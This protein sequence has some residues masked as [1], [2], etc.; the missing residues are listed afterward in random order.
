MAFRVIRPTVFPHAPESMIAEE[1]RILDEVGAELVPV[2]IAPADLVNHVAGAD[3]LIATSAPV[4]A[5]VIEAMP[6]CRGI[7]AASIGFDH[8]DLAAATARGIKVANVPDFCIREVANHTMGLLLACTRKIPRLNAA[9]HAGK[10][11]RTIFQP[12]APIHGETMGLIS[13]G[14]IARQVA[15]R[16]QAFELNVIA[17][18]PYVDA[19]TAADFGVELVPLEDL[20]RR[21]DYVSVHVPRTPETI[22]LIGAPELA[23]MKPTAMI[24]N[25]GRGGVIDEAALAAALRSGQLAG[26][27]LDVFAHEPIDQ[28]NPL[29]GIETAILTPHAAGYSELSIKTVRQSAAT[30]MARILAGEL[31]VNLVNPEVAAARA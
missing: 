12:M 14:R 22:N 15:K 21:S 31:P 20:L 9:T 11:D 27:G 3:G 25:T 2:S 8:I 4:T 10:W 23:L 29:L 5:A 28:D 16:A 24:F 17:Y 7:I 13:F 19:A 18:D 30:E 1:Q 6:N 26:A